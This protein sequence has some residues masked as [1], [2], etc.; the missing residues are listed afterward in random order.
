MSASHLPGFQRY[1]SLLIKGKGSLIL[2]CIIVYIPISLHLDANAI[3]W[4]P[5]LRRWPTNRPPSAFSELGGALVK[6]AQLGIGHHLV[7]LCLNRFQM[8]RS[9]SLSL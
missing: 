4:K 9:M 1:L 2:D 6:E 7:L 8:D 5:R 3:V